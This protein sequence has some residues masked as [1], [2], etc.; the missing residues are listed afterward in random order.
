[1]TEI[2]DSSGRSERRLFN[3]TASHWP[4]TELQELELPQRER[5]LSARIDATAGPVEVHNIHVPPA[6]SQGLDKVL[7]LEQVHA[8]LAG[9]LPGHRIL[10]GDF[11]LPR[12]E[13]PDGSIETFASNHPEDFE[14][15]DAA[16]R[17]LLEGLGDSDLVDC[18]RRV[19]GYDRSDLS[20]SPASRRGGGHRLDHI[21]ASRGL[22]VL[23]C[24]YHHGW[25]EEGLSDHSAMEAIFDPWRDSGEL[26]GQ[27][28]NHLRQ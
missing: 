21:L 2:V 22:N 18:F 8:G 11:N 28:A 17:L 27:P 1:L 25:R 5:L 12:R 15:W 19:H 4:V 13:Y 9:P 6:P 23:W 7:T 3:L 26:F 10:C 16:E 24:D 20:W 14:R